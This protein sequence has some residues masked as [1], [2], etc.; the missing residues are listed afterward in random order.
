MATPVAPESKSKGFIKREL[1]GAT[2][3]TL[4]HIAHMALVVVVSGLIVSGLGAAFSLWFGAGGMSQ[5]LLGD[6][7]LLLGGMGGK[8]LEATMA[9][10]V[11]AALLVLVPALVILDRRT[12]AEWHK[13]P[14][15]AGRLAYKVPVYGALAV[16]AAILI[17]LKIQLVYVIISSLAFIGVQGAQIGDMYLHS[18][19]PTLIAYAVFGA[20]AWYVFNLAK[21]RDNGRLFSLAKAVG[22]GVLAVALFIT[23][24]V[25]LHDGKNDTTLPAT[26]GESDGS[27]TQPAEPSYDEDYYRDLLEKYYQ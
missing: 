11:V 18:F 1:N 12:R 7:S 21:G 8:T 27:T 24:L 17:V 13:R 26:R 5:A 6:A 9:L 20:A 2:F 22:G 15:Y 16:L 10:G 4:E 14:G 3:L 23:A 19:I 25:A